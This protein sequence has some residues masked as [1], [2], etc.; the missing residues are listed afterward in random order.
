MTYFYIGC[1]CSSIIGSSVDASLS[2]GPVSV[3]LGSLSPMLSLISGRR[4]WRRSVRRSV[5]MKCLVAAIAP[6]W[7]GDLSCPRTSYRAKQGVFKDMVVGGS[8]GWGL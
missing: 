7:N 3:G 2:L 5:A 8:S 4:R 6:T 1:K